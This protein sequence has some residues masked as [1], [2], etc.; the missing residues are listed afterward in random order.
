MVRGER[1]VLKGKG[2]H[3]KGEFLQDEGCF[4][5]GLDGGLRVSYSS[6]DGQ[7]TGLWGLRVMYFPSRERRRASLL[8]LPQ[9]R[10]ALNEHFGGD[11]ATI[12][13]YAC[14]LGC[15]GKLSKPLGTPYRGRR[16]QYDRSQW[17]S[18]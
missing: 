13:G 8:R 17:S 7:A 18:R 4:S 12:H 3:P 15:E 10:V 6:L 9:D 16:R 14:A 5:G 2:Y 1:V 11:G